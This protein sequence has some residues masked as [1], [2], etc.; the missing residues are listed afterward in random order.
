MNYQLSFVK[1]F[2]IQVLIGRPNLT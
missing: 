2:D 1:Y